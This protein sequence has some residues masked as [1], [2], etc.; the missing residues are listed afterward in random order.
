MKRILNRLPIY[1]TVMLLSGIPILIALVFSVLQIQ[2]LQS[3]ALQAE[4]DAESVQTILLFDELAHNL[5]VERGLT[6]GV[7]GSKGN[8]EQVNALRKQRSVV[9]EKIASLNQF[10]PQ[11]IPSSLFSE[12]KS[13]VNNRLAQLA[14]V[15]RGVDA[16][17]PTIAPFD[18]YSDI[19]KLAIDNGQTLL[20]L[21]KNSQVASL[22]NGL[23]S[24][25]TIKEKAGQVRGALNGAFARKSST[26]QQ[27][28]A[29]N[30]YLTDAQYA[31]RLANILLP[32]SLQRSLTAMQTESV[33]QQVE[34]IQQYYIEQ[35]DHLD[36]LDG[37]QAIQWFSLATDRIKLLIQLRNQVEQMMV[38]ESEQQ[39]RSAT[40]IERTIMVVAVIV[41][42]ILISLL[43]VVILNLKQRV[44]G[45]TVQLRQMSD[46]RD[47]R[48]Q[49]AHDGADE[50]AHIASSINQLTQ[51]VKV[52]LQ[53]VHSANQHSHKTFGQI[54]D[55]AG[56]LGQSSEATT[57][58]C[59]SISAAITQ[60]SQSSVEIATSSERALEET[61]MMMS[62]T[63]EC[64]DQS[65]HSFTSVERLVEQIEQTQACMQALAA[66]AESVSKIVDTIT[67]I[68]E[69]TNLLALNAAIEAARAGEYGRGFAVVSTEVRD[70]AQRSKE[71][72]EHITQLLANMSQNT[73]KAVENM[74]K[75]HDATHATFE[76]VTT[77]DQSIAALEQV[78]ELVNEHIVSIANATTE[79]SKANED[80]DMDI[81]TLANIADHTGT[82]ARQLEDVVSNYRREVNEVSEKLDQFRLA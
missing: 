67:G 7:L 40:S 18:Y 43:V 71:A 50:I 44:R 1:I 49:F 24:I 63:T 58:K 26:A 5:A 34:Q 72:T 36:Q 48:Q 2:Q 64:Q 60:L 4:T 8:S 27:Y 13:D 81:N 14:E 19:N 51:S 3:Q 45:L 6:A 68:S 52:L 38:S 77:V 32:D 31:L 33:W 9:D 47:L 12:L 75:S 23:I 65:K 29:I 69:Q 30:Q 73:N 54:S 15:R 35:K 22:G 25:L 66:D 62:K 46:Q 53:D 28:T 55:N 42:V 39:M 21:I 74:N 10:S 79:Q 57:A 76:S 70:L 20:S 59:Q 80:V 82:L 17:A 37:P 11:F 56:D 61:R 41:A 78:I 16:L